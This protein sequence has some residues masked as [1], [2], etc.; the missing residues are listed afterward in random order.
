M[1]YNL[2]LANKKD[3]ENYQTAKKQ[4]ELAITLYG[5]RGQ[6]EEI[7]AIKFDNSVDH[8]GRPKEKY[9]ME[10]WKIGT[11]KT[12]IDSGEFHSNDIKSFARTFLGLQKYTIVYL[13]RV[14]DGRVMKNARNTLR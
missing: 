7:E 1:A 2:G 9:Y 14:R 12:H 13:K 11:P 6:Q 5:Q 4:V 3:E 8:A 10:W